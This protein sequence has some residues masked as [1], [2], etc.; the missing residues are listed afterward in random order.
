MKLTAAV[1]VS[2]LATSSALVNRTR[3]V[4]PSAG[5]GGK[6]DSFW[7]RFPTEHTIEITDSEPALGKRERSY[8]LVIP[9][10][11]TST[12]PW[13][14]LLYFHG[15]YG[16]ALSTARSQS[17]YFP[18]YISAFPQGLADTAGRSCGTGWNTGGNGVEDSCTSR[19]NSGSCCYESCR[20]LGKC[21][22]D[23]AS[24]KCS[25]STCWD[26]AAFT[27]QLI[28]E[29]GEKHC[30]DLNAVFL[31]GASNGGMAIYDIAAKIP[32]KISAVL[33]VYGLPTLGT[34]KVPAALKDVSY[35]FLSGRQDRI[36]PIDGS[37]SSGGWYYESYGDASR[38]Y[39][40]VHGCSSRSP[41]KI[42]TP[43][44]GVNNME[45]VEY[46]GCGEG[47][48]I[49]CLYDGG[50]SYPSGDAGQRLSRWFFDSVL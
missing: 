32:T 27:S 20:I 48:V 18:E 44:D 24:A 9:Q 34:L 30:I 4:R 45:C 31:S 7:A 33:P 41:S 3:A 16:R 13:P 10:E 8:A 2:S 21:S 17:P 6:K 42:E 28:D 49:D 39:A 14:L 38:A 43:A 40:D 25:W 19:A 47:R 29:I 36:V 46:S 23:G 15:Q 12:T 26:D 37:L 5:C 1:L 50:H 35:L 11:H 22:G